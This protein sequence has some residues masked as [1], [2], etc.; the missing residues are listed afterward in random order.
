MFEL[1]KM[2]SRRTTRLTRQYPGDCG[3]SSRIPQN[4][5][6]LRSDND[7]DEYDSEQDVNDL[8]VILENEKKKLQREFAQLK[9][10]V[11]SLRAQ[12]EKFEKP[13]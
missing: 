12:K 2:S 6:H 10:E 5:H 4:R 9:A 11:T 7:S 8:Q 3:R 13:E 1:A